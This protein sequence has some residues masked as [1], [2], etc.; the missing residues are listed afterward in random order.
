MMKNLTKTLI[1]S[2]LAV[3]TFA[4]SCKKDKNNTASQTS[5]IQAKWYTK[6]IV[7]TSTNA[8]TGATLTTSTNNSFSTSD[9]IIYDQSGAY[10][11][12]GS[13]YGSDNGKYSVSTLNTLTMTSQKS[14]TT[15]NYAVQQL[16]GSTLKLESTATSNNTKIV[17]D[18]TFSK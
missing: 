11:S 8:T 10:T 12:V 3:L 4:T 6:S 17:V 15:T 16:D 18:I 2:L 9:Y 13:P 1:L 5:K 14:N 7:T